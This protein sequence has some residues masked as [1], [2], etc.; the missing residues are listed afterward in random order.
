MVS[1]V[2]QDAVVAEFVTARVADWVEEDLLAERAEV[3][4]GEFL[5]FEDVQRV[6]AVL[7]Y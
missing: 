2:G 7:F 4:A 5:V 1:D 6:L 3:P